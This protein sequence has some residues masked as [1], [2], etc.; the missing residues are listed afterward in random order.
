MSRSSAGVGPSPLGLSSDYVVGL[1]IQQFND[2]EK[3]ILAVYEFQVDQY[4]V[5]ETNQRMRDPVSQRQDNINNLFVDFPW[6]N[7]TWTYPGASNEYSKLESRIS[8]W[9]EAHAWV[10]A[11][12]TE[13]EEYYTDFLLN[14]LNDCKS[15]SFDFLPG[16]IRVLR[17]SEELSLRQT[18]LKQ[19]SAWI[20]PQ[21]RDVNQLTERQAAKLQDWVRFESSD[22]E[23]ELLYM[24]FQELQTSI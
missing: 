12:L 18:S 8:V 7:F 9:K 22:I 20:G 10:G 2:M 23:G 16:P 17:R 15:N 4:K 14:F 13:D 11:K 1:D 24:E 5:T 21:N 3:S 19:L 6:L